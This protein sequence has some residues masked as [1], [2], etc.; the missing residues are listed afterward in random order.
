MIAWRLT[1]NDV[2]NAKSAQANAVAKAKGRLL[3]NHDKCMAMF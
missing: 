1:T 3:K 2:A